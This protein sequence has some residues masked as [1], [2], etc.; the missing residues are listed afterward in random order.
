MQKIQAFLSWIGRT[1]LLPNWVASR[2]TRLDF[3]GN[4]HDCAGASC[5]D[6][7]YV[8]RERWFY[9]SRGPC[10]SRVGLVL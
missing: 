9:G 2:P 7:R 4:R 5:I 10:F 3:I 8:N 6:R 1:R